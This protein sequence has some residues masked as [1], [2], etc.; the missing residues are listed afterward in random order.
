[1]R[2]EAERG[3]SVL[4]ISQGRSGRCHTAAPTEV[5]TSVRRG[6]KDCHCLK[7]DP[8][9]WQPRQSQVSLHTYQQVRA[10]RVL[11]E[12]QTQGHVGVDVFNIWNTERICK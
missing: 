3:G 2:A 8:G 1:M 9:H 7:K 6:H 11:G 5:H 12:S 4:H 10:F